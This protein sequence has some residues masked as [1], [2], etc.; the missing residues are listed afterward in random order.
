MRCEGCLLPWR[1]VF[2]MSS[3]DTLG[4]NRESGEVIL[5][6]FGAA[7]I[8]KNSE[9]C[10]LLSFDLPGSN[11]EIGEVIRISFGK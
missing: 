2:V 1:E 8:K 11:K 5:I 7:N 4:A 9:C 3:W 10:V 6:S